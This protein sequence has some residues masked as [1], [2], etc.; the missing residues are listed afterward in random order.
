M[1]NDQITEVYIGNEG[2]PNIGAT[3][4]AETATLDEVKAM[5]GI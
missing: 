5:F 1:L 3:L 2:E 4:K